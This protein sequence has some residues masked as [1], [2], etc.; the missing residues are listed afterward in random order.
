MALASSSASA[1]PVNCDQLTTG[2]VR[3]GNGKSKSEFG[4]KNKSKKSVSAKAVLLKR[5]FN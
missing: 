1:H 3:V 4:I 5:Y 2:C